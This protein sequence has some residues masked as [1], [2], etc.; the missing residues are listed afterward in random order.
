MKQY[1]LFHPQ[2]GVKSTQMKH[3]QYQEIN[4]S[5]LFEESHNL[6]SGAVVLFS[7]EV[8][9][10]NKGRSVEYIEYEAYE[11]MADKMIWEIVEEAKA[12]YKL[13][14]AFCIHRLGRIETGSCAVVVITSAGHRKEAYDA[15]Q[16]I[17]DCVKND[18]P[19]WKHEF[20]TD[21]SSEWG[22]NCD[23]RLNS[24][25]HEHKHE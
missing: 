16:Y 9:D 6:K 5:H 7:G 20:F 18:V 23:C 19:V 13:N 17:I 22:Q 4:Y 25:E 3:L 12:K 14:H 8:R 11:Q 21:G 10:I 24:S 2:A 15:N 1:I